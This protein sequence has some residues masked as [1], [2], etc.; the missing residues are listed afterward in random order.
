MLSAFGEL[1]AAAILFVGGHF[2]L[3]ATP[4]RERLVARFGQYGFLVLY[5]II[6]IAT[7][8][9][10]I[11]SFGRA[12]YVGIWG[13]PPWA[14]ALAFIIMP[15]SA[16]LVTAGYLT[17]NPSAVM[18]G[19]I[20]LQHD[21]PARGIFRIT[22]QP[23]MVGMALWAAVHVI[24]NGD[25]SAILLFGSILILAVGGIAHLE[26][27]RRA[28][29]DPRWRRLTAVT[30]ILPFSAIIEG[31]TRFA[32]SP[33]DWGRVVLGL[34]LYAVLIHIHGWAFGVYL[35]GEP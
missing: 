22:R 7:L 28:S 6:A 15:F 3:S 16:M 9:W 2:L 24:A 26:S 8:A 10:M 5:S 20:A 14:S 29:G 32:F 21:D 17:P 33:L 11:L 4:I 31:R 25:I 23:V 12:P 30:S 35:V 18:I 13:S 1:A 27:R 19:D 34:V